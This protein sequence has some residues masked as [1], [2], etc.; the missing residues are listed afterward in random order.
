MCSVVGKSLAFVVCVDFY[1]PDILNIHLSFGELVP[2][3]QSA[4]IFS[5]FLPDVYYFNL[6]LCC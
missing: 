2:F 4:Y 1:F 3:F 5:L 6:M